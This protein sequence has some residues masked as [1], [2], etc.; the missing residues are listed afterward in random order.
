MVDPSRQLQLCCYQLK[1]PAATIPSTHLSDGGISF[2]Q[3]HTLSLLSCEHILSI[4]APSLRTLKLANCRN[5]SRL[6]AMERLTVAFVIDCADN[7]LTLFPLEQLERLH[8][9]GKIADLANCSSR[10]LKLKNLSFDSNLTF[11]FGFG[12]PPSVPFLQPLKNLETLTT[13]NLGEYNVAGL[14]NLTSLDCSR[15]FGFT[16]V[17]GNEEV[18]PQLRNYHGRLT[19]AADLEYFQRPTH[20]TKVNLSLLEQGE[21]NEFVQENPHLQELDLSCQIT[22]FTTTL[23]ISHYDRV[24]S[25]KVTLPTPIS[26]KDTVIPL[27]FPPGFQSFTLSLHPTVTELPVYSHLQQITV[28]NCFVLQRINSLASVPYITI[29]NCPEIE[30][31]SGLGASQRCLV[32]VLC[33]SLKNSDLSNFGNISYLSIS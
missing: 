23:G 26:K 3:L 19:S 33:P 17:A 12:S 24:K 28:T 10:L 29:I 21:V 11:G 15:G 18:F 25:V 16:T 22:L 7:T 1:P 13:V 6:E 27:Q 14:S 20:S 2:E 4:S 8:F 5:I 32:L 9:K 31:F 30:D